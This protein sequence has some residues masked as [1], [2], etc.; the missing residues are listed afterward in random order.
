MQDA[1]LFYAGLRLDHMGFLLAFFAQDIAHIFGLE[2]NASAI[3]VFSA[4]S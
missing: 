4:Q 3:V 1:L 2:G